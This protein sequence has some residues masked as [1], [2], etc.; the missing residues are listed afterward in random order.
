MAIYQAKS[1]TTEQRDNGKAKYGDGKN[2]QLQ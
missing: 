2:G 1:Q